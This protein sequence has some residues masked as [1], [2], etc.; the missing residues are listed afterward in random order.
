VNAEPG[1]GAE[2]FSVFANKDK[3]GMNGLLL[4]GHSGSRFAVLQVNLGD[5]LAGIDLEA[6]LADSRGLLKAVLSN[7]A[8]DQ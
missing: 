3:H 7:P 8:L 4:M 1:L 6:L 2:G 5:E